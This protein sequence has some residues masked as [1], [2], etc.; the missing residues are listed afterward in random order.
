M[1]GAE[2]SDDSESA[3]LD[4]VGFSTHRV[5]DRFDAVPRFYLNVLNI[6]I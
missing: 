6:Y 1:D 3:V 2:G 5:V 4:A